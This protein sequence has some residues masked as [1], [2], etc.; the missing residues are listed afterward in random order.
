LVRENLV[1]ASDYIKGSL[2]DIVDFTPF[3]EP[4]VRLGSIDFVFDSFGF[5]WG[6]NVRV[7]P[8]GTDLQ[9]SLQID[10]Q[11]TAKA[12]AVYFETNSTLVASN[13]NVCLNCLVAGAEKLNVRGSTLMSGDLVA[14]DITALAYFVSSDR[15]LKRNIIPLTG[16]LEKALRLRGVSYVFKA[17]PN[18]A[19]VGLIAQEVEAV[20][21][22]AVVTMK[23]GM[24]AIDY[25]ALITL[26]ITAIQEQQGELNQ[27]RATL[28]QLKLSLALSQSSS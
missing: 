9:R 6:P 20:L 8:V 7:R 21:P 3:A 13:G 22:E 10:G 11:V 28:N 18:H 16:A 12:G 24:K 2:L 15:A 27:L 26:L 5:D 19:R 23:D 17:A 4:Y 1:A 14:N 25:T